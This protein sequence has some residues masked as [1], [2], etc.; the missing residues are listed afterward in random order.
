MERFTSSSLLLGDQ[1]RAAGD[2]YDDEDGDGDRDFERQIETRSTGPVGEREAGEGSRKS[3]EIERASAQLSIHIN[4]ER[5]EDEPPQERTHENEDEQNTDLLTSD[6]AVPLD[7]SNTDKTVVETPLPL[8]KMIPIM[9]LTASESFNSSA[10]F[11]Y[12]G[13]L[14]LDFNLTDDKKELGYYS[15]I[16]FYLSFIIYHLSFIHDG[17]ALGRNYAGAI[18]SCFFVAQFI[19][20]CAAFPL[21]CGFASVAPPRTSLC[22]AHTLF[23][24]V[25]ACARVCC[26]CVV[27]V[28]CAACQFLLG[29]DVR[30]VRTAADPPVRCRGHHHLCPAVRVI[31]ST[32]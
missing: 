28:L 30:Q 2:E 5:L 14:V 25:C 3:S 15:F 22:A 26:V 12:V 7:G 11:S 21:S 29:Q 20:R 32:L 8:G 4:G 6:E 23:V 17:L 24:C 13:Y 1:G 18:S 31:S 16:L 19:S 27:C 9:L 10:I